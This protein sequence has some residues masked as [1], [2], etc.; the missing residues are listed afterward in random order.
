MTKLPATV[1]EAEATSWALDKVRDEKKAGGIFSDDA[2]LR[3]GREPMK[4]W[5]LSHP[6]GADD[7]VYFA[8]NGSKEADLSLREVIAEKTDR[9][10]Q[11]GAVLSAYNIRLLN[12][13]RD[14]RKH[15]PGR[16]D[17]FVRDIGIVMLVIALMERFRL[18]PT[19][20]RSARKPAASKIAAAVLT[21]VNIPLS[22]RGVE[23]VW[24]HYLPVF[25]GTPYAT[26]SRFA[27]A[28]SI[29]GGPGLFDK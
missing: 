29:Y 2:Q 27:V 25:A 19:W 5:I 13:T 28:S 15:G 11:L 23:K 20:N 16:A 22:Y 26:L 24:Q 4:E 6:F 12:P 21:E 10:E 17:N 8:E 1:L 3:Y 18:A 9:G 7:I 14:R